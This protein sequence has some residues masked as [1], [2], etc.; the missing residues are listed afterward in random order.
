MILKQEGEEPP[1]SMS[2]PRP[3]WR[4]LLSDRQK[5]NALVRSCVALL[6]MAILTGC[7]VQWVSPY[8]AELQK[9]A[10][11][12]LADVVAWEGHMRG[13]A[14]TVAADPRNP[15]VQAKLEAWRGN[16]EA[17]SAIELGIDPGA[18]VCDK[19]IATISN[20]ISTRLK[21]ALPTAPAAASGTSSIFSAFSAPTPITH[22][23]TLP[24]IFT[25]MMK[26]VAPE[27]PAVPAKAGKPAIPAE[28]GLIEMALEQQCKLEWL[29]D[30]YFSALQGS[31]TTAKASAPARPV[32]AQSVTP[33]RATRAHRRIACASLFE[34]S[35]G[36]KH[37]DLLSSLIV[38]LDAII[39]REGREAPPS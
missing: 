11:D 26:Q 29:K 13:A 10:T 18:T 17:M 25:R 24:G 7:Q 1:K 30:D 8:S 5:H 20:G 33:S 36:S 28:K 9:K 16:I 35:G 37:G 34:P 21:K 22:C 39:Y 19:F 4:T 32:P 12:M 31:H 6:T 14:G 3:G 23:E 2:L 27:T 15:D 38:D